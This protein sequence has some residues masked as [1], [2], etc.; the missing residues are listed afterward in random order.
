MKINIISTL[1]LSVVI[2]TSVSCDGLITEGLDNQDR[3]YIVTKIMY[4]SNIEGNY[5]LYTINPDG[6]EQKK[7]INLPSSVEYHSCWSPDGKY[8]VFTSDFYSSGTRQLCIAKENGTEMR[9]L[10]QIAGGAASPAWSPDG[11]MIAFL[12]NN[13]V[14]VMN[15]DGTDVRRLT[16]DAGTKYGI[17]WSRDSK[18]VIYDLNSSTSI[19]SI[20]ADGSSSGPSVIVSGYNDASPVF[21][22]DGNYIYVQRNDSGWHVFRINSDG[23]N[24]VNLTANFTLLSAKAHVAI[25]PDG[26]GIYFAGEETVTY[27]CYNVY[28]WVDANTYIR[29]T[30]NFA[31]GAATFYV[32]FKTK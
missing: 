25:S 22:P 6:T 16:T 27:T 3:E 17:S 19:C 26:T 30:N 32:S 2:I 8:V 1:I 14:Y 10:L 28:K 15:Y 18:R 5:E 20:N 21:S 9:L 24:P 11:A 4:T 31:S 23:T 29:L 12:N 13:D 7:F